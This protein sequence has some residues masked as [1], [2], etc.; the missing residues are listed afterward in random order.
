MNDGKRSGPS[1]MIPKDSNPIRPGKIELVAIL[2]L[3]K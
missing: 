1:E 2:E 3:D